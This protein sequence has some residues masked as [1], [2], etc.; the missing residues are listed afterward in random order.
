MKHLHFNIGAISISGICL[1]DT[2]RYLKSY[3]NTLEFFISIYH[4][5]HTSVKPSMPCVLSI[6]Y[7]GL[8]VVL[9]CDHLSIDSLSFYCNY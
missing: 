4:G 9:S 5:V 2:M 7:L 6:Y 3:M 1:L 8:T